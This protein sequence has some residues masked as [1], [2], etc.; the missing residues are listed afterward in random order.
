M[1]K[2]VDLKRW[3]EQKSLAGSD[4]EPRDG[5]SATFDHRAALLE[6]WRQGR[7]L[8]GTPEV[9][10]YLT[11]PLRSFEKALEE[12]ETKRRCGN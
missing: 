11:L 4:E 9:S 7:D 2:V 1:S 3:R 6:S 12:V 8:L 10:T 5:R